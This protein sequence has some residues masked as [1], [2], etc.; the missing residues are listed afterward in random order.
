MRSVEFGATKLKMSLSAPDVRLFEPLILLRLVAE[1]SADGLFVPA[2]RVHE[3]PP[4]PKVLSHQVAL[5]LPETRARWIA[6]LPLMNPT[7]CD[8]SYFGEIDSSLCT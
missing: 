8:T 5:A 6:L 4:R 1:V 7:T 3:E 2:D